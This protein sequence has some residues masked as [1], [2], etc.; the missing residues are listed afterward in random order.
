MSGQ[1]TNMDVQ[2]SHIGVEKNDCDTTLKAI[3]NQPNSLVAPHNSWPHPQKQKTSEC[4]WHRAE[5][6][7][8]SHE[9]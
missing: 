1:L 9:L 6:K 4:Q 3:A 5:N 7:S 8:G 2:K